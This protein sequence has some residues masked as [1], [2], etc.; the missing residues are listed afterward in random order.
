MNSALSMSY[1][2]MRSYRP[3]QDVCFGGWGLQADGLKL[4]DSRRKGGGFLN[5]ALSMSYFGM[6]SYGGREGWESRHEGGGWEGGEMMR[7]CGLGAGWVSG[8]VMNSACRFRALGTR[9]RC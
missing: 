5:S 3:K 8:D 7:G 2:G 4:E 6:R 1:F 9:R